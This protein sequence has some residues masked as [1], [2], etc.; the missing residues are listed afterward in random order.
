[1]SMQT[2]TNNL[3]IK[4]V[5][6]IILGCL[7]SSIGLNMFIVHAKLYSGGVSGLA[8]LIQYITK[9]PAGYTIMLANIPLLVISFKKLN[10]RF[11]IYSAIGTIC[12]SVFLVATKDMQS[13]IITNDTLLYCLYGGVLNGLGIGLTFANH[14]SMGGINIITML[15]KKKHDNYDVGKIGLIFNCL[16]LCI[17]ALLNGILIALYTLISMYIT[18]V[19]TDK[20]IHGMV[21]KKLLFIITEKEKE[22]CDYIMTYMHRGATILNG[23]TLTGKER[24]VLYC[25]VRL[26][27]LPELKYS[28]QNIDKDALISIIDASEVDG[29]G[30]DNSI[31]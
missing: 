4:N 31:L 7:L 14:G 19:V 9:F 6:L 23:Q 16:I 12:Y 18:S 29:K 10:V 20:I 27:H 21:R 28:I 22:V 17:A 2:I 15:F 25:I 30:F 8:I 24:K 5:V 3:R 11:T 13:I 1:M 26:S